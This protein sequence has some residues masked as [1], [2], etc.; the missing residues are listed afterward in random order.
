MGNTH[1]KVK[2]FGMLTGTGVKCQHL[3][4]CHIN[5]W[6]SSCDQLKIWIT[7]KSVQNVVCD[8][9]TRQGQSDTQPSLTNP[10]P[11]SPF[12]HEAFVNAILNFIVADDQVL[13]LIPINIANISYRVSM[14]L[15]ALN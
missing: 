15:R 8:Y 12:S 11:H 6:V 14:S 7:A 13:Y 5:L 9:R 3:V 10:V 4:D 1:V 2:G